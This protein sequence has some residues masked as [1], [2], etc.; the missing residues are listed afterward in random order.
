MTNA[1]TRQIIEKYIEAY[2]AFDVDGMIR[3]LHNDVVFRNISNGEANMETR[4]V[5]AF[6]ELADRSAKMFSA[7][8]QTIT[9]YRT[10]DSKI[11]V[12]IEYIGTLA[13]DLPNGLKT[14][15]HLQ[16]EGK[17]LFEFKDGKISLI[18]DYS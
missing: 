7:R 16:L 12:R 5:Q 6:R 17:S 18:E 4:G 10:E 3:L 14:G 1:D 15:D 13:V 2:N 8:R 9:G 11:E